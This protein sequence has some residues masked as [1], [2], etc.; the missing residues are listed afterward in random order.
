M[1][2]TATVILTSVMP[3]RKI[4]S[5]LLWTLIIGSTRKVCLRSPP[6]PLHLKTLCWHP[7]P[8]LCILNSTPTL[9]F[10]LCRTPTSPQKQSTT[11]TVTDTTA[12]T[13]PAMPSPNP[14]AASG[15]TQAHS[16]ADFESRIVAAP[17]PHL[18]KKIV[19]AEDKACCEACSVM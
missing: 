1:Q 10:A 16:P 6:M 7:P 15:I 9:T 17:K 4:P 11:A 5:D 12:T 19:E 3:G 2:L 18:K 14:E 8:G 13:S